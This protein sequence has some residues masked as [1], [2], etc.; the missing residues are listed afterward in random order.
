MNTQHSALLAAAI[1][2][3]LA[4][5]AIAQNAPARP[6]IGGHGE[7]VTAFIAQHDDN[8]DGKLTWAEFEAFRRARFDATD[9]NK[10]GTVD[11]EEYASEYETRRIENLKRERD[12]Q[13]AQTQTRFAALDKDK[14][15]VIARAEFDASGE[16]VYA[17]GQKVLA[18]LDDGSDTALR[19][20]DRNA[21]AP[22]SHTAEGF[23]ALYDANSDGQVPRAEF[24]A[25]RDEQFT[26]TDAN[27]NGTIDAS[28]YQAEFE[29]RMDARMA[30]LAK[31][32]DTQSRVRFAAL[33]ADKDG[34]MTF[35]EYQVSGKRLFD[36]ADRNHDGTVDAQDAKLPPPERPQAN[37]KADKR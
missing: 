1:A 12:G 36:A 13:V 23:L 19:A 27:G 14:D 34:A 35:A 6:V 21:L 16:R 11:I 10:N 32:P 25:K 7:N 8:G 33:D 5:P 17:E 26:R 37:D 28:E 24:D 15:G 4:T 30:E 18:A 9:A 20:R 31:V 29:A 22:T 2:C 3:I